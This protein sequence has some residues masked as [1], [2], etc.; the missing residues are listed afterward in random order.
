MNKK[1]IIQEAN[2]INKIP[3]T[4]VLGLHSC[5]FYTEMGG[6]YRSQSVGSV[7][8]TEPSQGI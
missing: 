4:L 3:K 8:N 1:I 2:R 6:I 5:F 7:M